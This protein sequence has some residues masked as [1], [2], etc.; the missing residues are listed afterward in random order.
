MNKETLHILQEDAVS[1][2]KQLVAIP[3]LSREEGGTAD[4]IQNYLHKKKII[5]HRSGNNVWSSNKYFD[6]SK[7]TILLNSHHDTVP[8][9]PGYTK[10]PYHPEITEGKLYGLGST[11][12][13]ASLVCLLTT[14]AFFYEKQH[15]Q[16]N[17]VFAATAE[18]EVSGQNGIES[19]FALPQFKNC[20]HHQKSFA[21]VGEPTK[22]ELAIAE[23]G[24][25]VLDC[26]V[27][28]KAG[29]AAR[30]EGDNAIYKALPAINWF[31]NHRFDKISPLLG[32]V[33]MNVTSIGTDNKAHNIIPS[34]CHFVVDVRI[35]E[36]YTHDEI[37]QTIKNNVDA[38]ITARSKRL[39]PSSI[40]IQHP[41][42]QTGVKLG[43]KTFGSPTLSDQ[44]LI[45]LPSLKC[46]PGN[47]A[48][49]HTADEFILL[50]DIEE[51]IETYI[52]LLQQIV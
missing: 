16:Y 39:R 45:P 22:M 40:D 21:I 9:D 36:M 17:I 15:L 11:D 47:S 5:V 44:A 24:L 19:L 30:D 42:V 33:K 34:E 27:H 23:K 38:E 2:L 14:F 49:S 43:K 29:H 25:L 12:A 20:F 7:P 48:Q 37:L 13:G 52:E 8:P 18:E 46:G 4:C 28:G 51:G 41:A 31:K 10:D 6:A 50:T 3:S 1:L 26:V 35:T 32:P